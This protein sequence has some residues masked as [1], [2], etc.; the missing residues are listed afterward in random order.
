M[1]AFPNA[2][3]GVLIPEGELK[4]APKLNR[5]RRFDWLYEQMV[6]S[7]RLKSILSKSLELPDVVWHRLR[8]ETDHELLAALICLLTAAL[9][10][11]GNGHSHWRSGRRLVLA[12]AVVIVETLRKKVLRCCKKD[13]LKGDLRSGPTVPGGPVTYC[14][15]L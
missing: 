6:T 9:A 10:D 2:F 3:L 7:R 14:T 4:A 12:T 1:E 11:K 8:S 15:R 5:G 13:G